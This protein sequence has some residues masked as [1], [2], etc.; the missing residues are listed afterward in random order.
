MFPCPTKTVNCT[1]L[2]DQSLTIYRCML[3]EKMMSED[4]DI[5][6]QVNEFQCLDA[7]YLF[8]RALLETDVDPD[9]FSNI[10][11]DLDSNVQ[12]K[13]FE[14]K[15]IDLIHEPGKCHSDDGIVEELDESFDVCIMDL[16]DALEKLSVSQRNQTSNPESKLDQPEEAAY[17]LDAMGNGNYYSDYSKQNADNHLS[18]GV[19]PDKE[20]GQS[21]GQSCDQADKTIMAEND[22]QDI[23]LDKGAHQESALTKIR[24][25]GTKMK[26][27]LKRTKVYCQKTMATM[28]QKMTRNSVFVGGPPSSNRN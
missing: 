7:D 9:L 21:S 28:K 23:K 25:I 24:K 15:T 13:R 10:S 20:P 26:H 18:S 8:D 5:S 1:I 27:A 4:N 6:E 19:A 2:A 14:P 11:V 3:F 12:Q 16:C 17:F 22:N